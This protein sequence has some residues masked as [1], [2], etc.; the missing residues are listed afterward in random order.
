[1]VKNILLIG[2][3]SFIK[4]FENLKYWL[5][6]IF[7]FTLMYNQYTPLLEMGKTL[8]IRTT[9]LLF[10][11]FSNSPVNYLI[12]LIG[13]VFIFSNAPFLDNNQPFIIIRSGK[14][15]W[16]AGK[17]FYILLAS[18]IYLFILNIISM[19][20]LLRYGTF[21]LEGWGKLV[22]TLALTNAGVEFD[23]NITILPEFIKNYSPI[24][25]F[26]KSF[27]M[28]WLVCVFLGLIMFNINL[29]CDKNYGGFIAS[30]FIVL[31]ILIF[32]VLHYKF[33]KISPVSLGKLTILQQ[34]STSI[35]PTYTYGLVFLISSIIILCIVCIWLNHNMVINTRENI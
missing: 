20:I 24:A 30:L 18:F 31:D 9:P 19:V 4:W 10:V 28:Q 22:N 32:N 7:L 11:F 27:F 35:F 23:V 2:F 16:I 15:T 29:K 5:V 14:K 8:G 12:I 25:A 33:Y 13:M 21:N 34:E 6:F 1:M 3:N 26:T 17:I